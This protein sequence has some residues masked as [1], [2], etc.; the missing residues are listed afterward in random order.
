MITRR[1]ESAKSRAGE[2]LECG[3]NGNP[4]RRR[5]GLLGQASGG[6]CLFETECV[7]GWNEMSLVTDTS[8]NSLAREKNPFEQNEL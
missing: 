5:Q 7:K 3:D 8:M 6:P 1:P 2:A 4:P